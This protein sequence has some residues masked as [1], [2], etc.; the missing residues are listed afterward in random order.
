MAQLFPDE[1]QVASVSGDVTLAVSLF[2]Q[3]EAGDRDDAAGQ[4]ISADARDEA[5]CHDNERR[6]LERPHQRRAACVVHRL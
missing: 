2:N 4:M 1:S 3:Q 6:D 5:G